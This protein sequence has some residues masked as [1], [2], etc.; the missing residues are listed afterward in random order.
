[1]TISNLPYAKQS[2]REEIF[3]STIAKRSDIN[4]PTDL[5]KFFKPLVQAINELNSNPIRLTDDCKVNIV[6]ASVCA[7]GP[8][9]N[10]IHGIC[11][12]FRWDACKYCKIRLDDIRNMNLTGKQ[13]EQ[14]V[15]STNHL[16][17]EC[18]HVGMLFAPDVFHDLMEGKNNFSIYF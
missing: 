15:I 9:S 11:R 12:S 3:L 6:V 16:L 8:A 2:K 4:N 1:M 5:E 17:K 7:D 14:R 13:A 18:C 10:E